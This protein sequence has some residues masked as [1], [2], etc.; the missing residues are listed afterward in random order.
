MK[1]R[2]SIIVA[3]VICGLVLTAPS[4]FSQGSLTPPGPPAPTMKSLDQIEARTPITNTGAVTISQS[5]SYYLTAN[6]AVS[7]NDA[8]TISADNVTLD[9]NGFTTSS[10]ANPAAG[11]GIVLSGGRRNITINNGFITGS[12]TVSSGVYSG[13]GFAYGITYSNGTPTLTRVSGVSVTGCQLA[14]IFLNLNSTSIQS[15]VVDTVGD[16]GLFAA[17][18]SDSVA[19]NCASSGVYANTADNCTGSSTT[20]GYGVYAQTANNCLGSSSTGTGLYAV[21][22]ATCCE[23]YTLVSGVALQANS[24][25]NCLGYNPNGTA[26]SATVANNCYGES[27]GSGDGITAGVSANNSYGSTVS[28]NGITTIVAQNSYGYS[29]SGTGLSTSVAVGCYGYSST[30]RGIYGDTVNFSYGLSD[31]SGPFAFAVY[32]NLIAEGTVG[33]AGNFVGIFG[34]AIL[35]SCW[36]AEGAAQAPYQYNMP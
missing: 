3:A 6:I 2:M 11:N 31:G 18:V 32:A 12:V 16:T 23:G 15:C 27:Q 9:L 29:Y 33:E 1:T 8:I 21:N 36:S 4:G 28:G 34:G 14:G 22:V 13:A 7:S 20:S 25:N 24:A 5:G 30:Y 10:T 19:V 17:L 26:I 35:N